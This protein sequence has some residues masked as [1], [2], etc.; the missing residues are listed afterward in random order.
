MSS[1]SSL[2]HRSNL[3]AP[4][5]SS[6]SSTLGARSIAVP[7]Q[8]QQLPTTPVNKAPTVYSF[9]T[10]YNNGAMLPDTPPPQHQAYSSSYYSMPQ[11]KSASPERRPIHRF[12]SPLMSAPTFAFA[13][14]STSVV[15]AYQP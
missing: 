6:A 14:S 9:E 15:P 10:Q 3:R 12:D 13:S 4:T 1:H 7:Q 5:T 8:Q 11:L 2:H